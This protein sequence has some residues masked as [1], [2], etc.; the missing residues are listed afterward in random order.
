[1]PNPE[2]SGSFVVLDLSG[3]YQVVV[4][5]CGCKDAVPPYVQP[6]C[7]RWFPAICGG[8]K[9]TTMFCLLEHFHL[10]SSQSNVS[11]LNYYHSLLRMTNN[12]GVDLPMVCC[13]STTSPFSY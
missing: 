1:M 8:M 12:T 4:Q 10:L 6:L 3:F 11:T 13:Y 5:F 7:Q 9:T 2:F